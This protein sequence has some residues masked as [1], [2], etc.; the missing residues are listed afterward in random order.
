MSRTL[1]LDSEQTIYQ[2]AELRKQLGE[3]LQAEDSLTLDLSCIGEIDCAGLQV[4]LWLQQEA[5][6]LGKT[7]TLSRPSR[8]M[9][10]FIHLLG[11][12]QRLACAGGE[13]GS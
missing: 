12:E 13:D 7:L 5:A 10:D 2:A 4:L 9:L 6:R 11:L 3:A 1:A 8:P